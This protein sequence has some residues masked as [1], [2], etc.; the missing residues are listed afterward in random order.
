MWV[1]SGP[2]PDAHGNTGHRQRLL[3]WRATMQVRGSRRDGLAARNLRGLRHD[4]L[5]QL[6]KSYGSGYVR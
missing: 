1:T 4:C 5:Q 2:R 3:L 6:R